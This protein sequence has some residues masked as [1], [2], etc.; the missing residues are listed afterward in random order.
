MAVFSGNHEAGD[1][2]AYVYRSMEAAG[3]PN[4]S[5][6]AIRAFN[7]WS[8]QVVGIS[9]ESGLYAWRY[10]ALTAGD[11][12]DDRFVQRR[13][14]IGTDSLFFANT[15]SAHDLSLFYL[16][17]ARQGTA[18]GFYATAVELLSVHNAI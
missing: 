17:L 3:K 18:Q 15:Y 12:V 14:L 16:Y 4:P 9:A 6:N 10:G 7:D 8:R 1:V 11:S 13:L 2:L 5:G